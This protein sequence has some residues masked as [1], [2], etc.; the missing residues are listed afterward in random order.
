MHRFL[1]TSGL[2][3]GL[4][5]V[6][7]VLPALA[8]SPTVYVADIGGV[9][10]RYD[11]TTGNSGPLLASAQLNGAVGLAQE[12]NGDLLVSTVGTNA[13]RRINHATNALTVLSQGGLLQNPDLMGLIGPEV[14]VNDIV[15]HAI[16]GVNTTTGAQRTVVSGGLS[17]GGPWMCSGSD[18]F[19]YVSRNSN[20]S[21]VRVNPANGAENVV[22][23][24]GLLSNIV[25]IAYG[26][27]HY[28][29]VCCS[30]VQRI[31]R[32]D[33]SSGAQVQ[34]VQGG[35]PGNPYGISVAADGFLWVGVEQTDVLMRINPGTGSMDSHTIPGMS[36][37]YGVLAGTNLTPPPPPPS[38]LPSCSASEDRPDSV[39]VQWAAASGQVDDYEIDRDGV[40]IA[41]VAPTV[42]QYA[43]KPA[44][45]PHNYCVRAAN[46]G[47]SSNPCCDAGQLK[48]PVF[49]PHLDFVRDVPN[50]QGGKVMLGW[51]RS[52]L[53]VSGGSVIGYRVWRRLPTSAQAALR[54]AGGREIRTMTVGPQTVYWEALADL[55]AG[56]LSGYGY[57]AATTQDSLP[58]SNPF[59]AF[60]VSALTEYQD[61]FYDSNVDSGYSVDNL[62]PDTPTGMQGAY[63]TSGG[64]KI[65]WLPSR[66]S[67]VGQYD[68]YRGATQNFVPSDLNRL[69][70]TTDTTFV[71]P[72]AASYFYKL[73]AV[74]VH[75][76]QSGFALLKP[77]DIPVSALV[78]SFEAD[79]APD[80]VQITVDLA[81]T[82]GAFGVRLW[83]S[84][85][86]S[87]LGAVA[88][89]PDAVPMSSTH[90]IYLDI[91][92]PKTKL[93]YWV[94]LVGQSGSVI[95]FG[96]V[97]VVPAGAFPSTILLA[98]QPN[99]ST[100]GVDFGYTIG[101]DVAGT[102]TAPVRLVL[103]D[104]RGKLVRVLQTGSQPV[105]HYQV[106]WD[107]NDEHGV[108]LGTGV[109][110][111]RLE[112]GAQI[113]SGKVIHI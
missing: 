36:Q 33:P 70:T 37:P 50:D 110:Q 54:I 97:T 7:F 25:G 87:R 76:N 60:F 79:S 9:I 68:V 91:S 21:V 29:Y 24:A 44:Q 48:P 71:D 11:V 8:D 100:S 63:L 14:F 101:S 3:F 41:S 113:H 94:D 19:L 40:T 105:G 106:H 4:L 61:I 27:D 102:G 30:G 103:F 80:G 49:Q 2:L 57:T 5:G 20:S 72:N 111:Y 13:I 88:L 22:S 59:T 51:A 35:F 53:D 109:Y 90:Y 108:R 86:D 85:T 52:D 93:W 18:G 55:P 39:I 43:D 1:R 66:A 65:Q 58:G 92:A 64:I 112:V 96:P 28:L 31:V 16:F 56:H 10:Y 77:S 42:F 6:A 99:P 23:S 62:A 38:D 45:G 82:P 75:G 98:P 12:A 74:D 26:P 84:E 69:G 46:F 89:T 83:R 67:D 107:G 95:S 104:S 81:V 15:A 47:G 17:N 34:I 32:V 78:Q 73:S